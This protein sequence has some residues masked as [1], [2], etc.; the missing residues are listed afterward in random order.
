MDSKCEVK[1]TPGPWKKEINDY[2]RSLE[3]TD[4]KGKPIANIYSGFLCCEW[5][6]IM[7]QEEEKAN[8][9]L[10]AAAPDMYEALKELFKLL[11]GDKAPKWR[12]IAFYDIA[13]KALAKAEGVEEDERL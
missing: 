7:T 3:I 5:D 11:E 10:I 12:A 9:N 1:H 2:D 6:F 13:K 8:A 4:R